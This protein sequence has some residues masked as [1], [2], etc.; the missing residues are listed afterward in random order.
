M[1]KGIVLILAAI[2]F[3]DES[4][5]MA[6]VLRTFEKKVIDHDPLGSIWTKVKGDYNRDGRID[7]MV[8]DGDLGIITGEH[9]GEKKLTILSFTYG[10]M[11]LS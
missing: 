2:F 10:G 9:R 8:G 5:N 11:T 7:F 6:Q 1:N 3:G 4:V